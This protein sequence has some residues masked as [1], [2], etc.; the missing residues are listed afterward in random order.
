[1]DSICI[2]SLEMETPLGKRRGE[3]RLTLGP[4]TLEGELTLFTRVLPITQGRRTGDRFTFQT[5]FGSDPY[6]AEG[7]LK[8]NRL[9][10]ELI[11]PAGR[12][13]VRGVRKQL[14]RD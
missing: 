11:T 2:Y 1:M 10:M 4:E 14:R 8:E 7:T 5:Q 12:Y 9:T 6:Q 3:L 13:P